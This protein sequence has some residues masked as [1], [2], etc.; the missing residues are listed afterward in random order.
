VSDSGR[1][2]PEGTLAGVG[3]RGMQ[4]RVGQFGGTLKITSTTA[5]TTVIA[6]I[7]L[8][9]SEVVEQAS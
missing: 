3:L 9:T 7:P 1:G 4:E 2:I 6:K 8:T 5:G